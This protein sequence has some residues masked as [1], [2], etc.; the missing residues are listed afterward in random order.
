[1]TIPL[2]EGSPDLL[3]VESRVGRGRITM[4]T[5]NPTD[6]ALAV[7]EGLDTLVRRVVLRRPEEALVPRSQD[8]RVVRSATIRTCRWAAPT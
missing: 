4:L 2:G 5:V 8:R 1:M 6:P 7:W 3:A